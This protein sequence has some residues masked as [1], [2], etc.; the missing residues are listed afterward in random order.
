MTDMLYVAFMVVVWYM[1]TSCLTSLTDHYSDVTGGAHIKIWMSIPE[2]RE[3]AS[4]G[5]MLFA[6][7]V[8]LIPGINFVMA[9][10]ITI[11][12]LIDGE[13]PK[14]LLSIRPFKKKQ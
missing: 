13:T 1:A 6:T 11:T 10:G 9:I 14:R 8:A 4:F 7:V 3:F 12:W 5:P 2:F